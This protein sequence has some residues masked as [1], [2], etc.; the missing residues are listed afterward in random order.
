M[1]RFAV[2]VLAV[3]LFGT[4]A[5]AAVCS[6]PDIAQAA[7][8]V[9]AARQ[10]LQA[11]RLSPPHELAPDPSIPPGAQTAIVTIKAR[12]A[13]LVAAYMRCAAPDIDPKTARRELGALVHASMPKDVERYGDTLDVLVAQ[14][15][16]HRMILNAGFN[17]KCANDDVTQVF[18]LENGLWRERLR[19]AGGRYK[20]T[21]GATDGLEVKLSVA[22]NDGRW[23]AVTKSV[24]PW[25]SSTWSGIKYSVLRPT[26]DPAKPRVLLNKDDFIW[27]GSDDFGRLQVGVHDFELRFHAESI[28]IGLFSR[29]WVR[30]FSVEGDTVR[31]IPPFAKN[32]R[33]FV[34]E[35]IQSPWSEAQAWT[36]SGANLKAVHDR[37]HAKPNG[38]FQSVRRCGAVMTQIEIVNE[39]LDTR[40]VFEVSGTENFTMTRVSATPDLK[41]SGKNLYD[42]NKP[43]DVP[44]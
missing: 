22:D 42:P 15:D 5:E 14:P 19:L 24:V 32:A 29:E 36:A 4:S 28:D 10:S 17:V 33:E 44:G 25:C 27:W 1:M 3:G 40:T 41:C 11:F 38:E 37:L 21:A 23:F 6:K 13:D 7:A 35:W 43:G 16:S 20:D 31:R 8:G 39:E 26:D 18:A 30:H 2:L 9:I 34:E 12:L